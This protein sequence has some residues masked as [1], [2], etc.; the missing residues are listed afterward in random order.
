MFQ[1]ILHSI[2]LHLLTGTVKT[3]AHRCLWYFQ[4]GCSS[5]FKNN[6]KVPKN[7]Y[8]K[9]KI[10]GSSEIISSIILI[11]ECLENEK[12]KYKLGVFFLKNCHLLIRSF[13]D[14]ILC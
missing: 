2:I 12:Y 11:D 5:I 13:G 14:K 3:T 9:L 1:D 10:F 8:S 6:Y 4:S 7:P